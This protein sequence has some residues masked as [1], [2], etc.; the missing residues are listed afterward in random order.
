MIGS[1]SKYRL[2]Y[3][4][5]LKVYKDLTKVKDCITTIPL[6]SERKLFYAYKQVCRVCSKDGVACSFMH[7][8]KKERRTCNW[9]PWGRGLKRKPLPCIC[10]LIIMGNIIFNWLN[11]CLHCGQRCFGISQMKTNSYSHLSYFAYSTQF[12]FLCKWYHI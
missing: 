12:F 4:L 9:K 5:K 11:W 3:E 2:I 6:S 1:F 7:E 10:I 8:A